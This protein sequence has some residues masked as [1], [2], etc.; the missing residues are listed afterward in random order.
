MTS[1]VILTIVALPGL[2]AGLYAAKQLLDYVVTNN[3]EVRWPLDPV[4]VP[5]E[6]VYLEILL[7]MVVFSLFFLVFL[8][9]FYRAFRQLSYPVKVFSSLLL[10]AQ[11]VLLFPIARHLIV[12]I[13]IF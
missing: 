3:H 9:V 6:V 2:I 13:H 12:G 10:C 4:F 1:I 8:L 11:L 5:Q 7:A